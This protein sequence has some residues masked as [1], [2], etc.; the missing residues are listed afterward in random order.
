M[1]PGHKTAL[2]RLLLPELTQDPIATREGTCVVTD[3]GRV[4]Y[5]A[6]VLRCRPGE[7]M[8]AVAPALAA[9]YLAT[10]A[11]V[12][13]RQ[14]VLALTQCIAQ[15]EEAPPVRV[16]LVAAVLKESHWDWL[17]QKATEL[18]VAGIYPLVTER[19]VVD[20]AGLAAKQERWQRIV[21]S[22]VLQ[23]EALRVPGVQQAQRL[24]SDWKPP[25]ADYAWLLQERDAGRYPLGQLW[26]P[27]LRGTVVIAV[28][29]E[30][31]WSEQETVWWVN[32]WGFQPVTLGT[33]VLR[34]E[35][36]ALT[37]LAYGQVVAHAVGCGA[38]LTLGCRHKP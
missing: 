20:V 32:Q 10:V 12:D 16:H 35:T 30:G 7:A 18:G 11:Q 34:A 8:V 15:Q 37:A 38:G 5:L 4:H 17:L 13:K 14:V 19:T 26:T 31:G 2:R 22:A 23:C 6:R 3:P 33:S 9:A 25:S 27:D 28:G 36:A 21:E 29:P 1:T 24:T